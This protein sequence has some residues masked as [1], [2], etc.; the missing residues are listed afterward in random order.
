[1]KI[2]LMIL[3]AVFFLILFKSAGSQNSQNFKQEK[4]SQVRIFSQGENADKRIID[5]GLL[6]DHA[7]RKADYTDA[8]L[9]ESEIKMLDNSGV[10]YN[11]LIPDW[12]NYYE[13]LPKMSRSEIQ[14]SI[15]NSSA[16]FNVSHSIYGTMGGFLKYSEVTAKLDSMRLQYPDLISTKFSIGSTV[17]NRQIWTV[18][19]TKNPDSPTG[20]PEAWYHSLIHA[21]EPESMQHM[22]FYIYWLLENY[23]IDPIAAYILNNRELY[24]TPVLNPDGYVYNETTNPN[25]GGMWRK[26]RKFN[27]SNYGVDL[28]RNYGIYQ[29]WNSSN[30]GSSTSTSSSTYRGTSPFSESETQAAMN[31]INS[32]NINSV[33][34]SHTYGN[35]IIKP[36]AWSDPSPTPD[37]AKFNEY[38]ADMS[39]YNNYI[40]G[41]PL[42]TVGYAVRGCA[43]DW[44]Y[45]DSAH[46]GHNII[47]VT[48]ETGLTGFWPAQS[49]IIP[50]AE[51]MLFTNQYLALISGAYVFPVSSNLN[52]QIYIPGESGTLNLIFKNKG[53][54]S[55]QNVKVEV[56][57]PSFYLNIPITSFN[58]STLSSFQSDSSIFGF[59]VSPA[60]PLNSALPLN[61]KFR[62][63]DS[64]IVYQETKY[65][66]TGNGALTLSDSAE[67]GF[68]K[69][70]TNSGWA[71]T[72]SQSHTPNNSFTD[73][74]SGNYSNNTNNSMTLNIPVDISSVPV[75]FLNFWHRYNTEA[76]YDFCYV[77]VSSNN[78]SSWQTVKSYNGVM[79]TWTEQNIDITSFA[80]S[81][82]QLKIRFRLQSDQGVVADGWY[83]DDIKLKN[84]SPLINSVVTNLQLTLAQEGLYNSAQ[85][86][87]NMNDTV[88][89]YLKSVTSP[90]Q[91]IDSSRGVIDSL[92]FTG[93]FGFRNAPS[94]NY[95]I[96]VKHRNSIET[97]SKAGGEEY[98]FGGTLSYDFTSSVS[99]AFGDNMILTGSKYCI[100]S[101][102]ADQNGFV[103]I[104]DGT[105]ID[106]D[107]AIF[108][109]GY[110]P[111][112]LNGDGITDV[113]DAVFADNNSYN[114]IS[115]IVP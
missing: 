65:V 112:D 106:N 21:R 4:Y 3:A 50:L 73:S 76:G 46:T 70:T 17:E 39:R 44:Y 54:L 96:M 32:R 62:Q 27:G 42:S 69:W 15:S 88:S 25:G 115:K 84:Y 80:N 68:G 101:A 43:D 89:V 8:W 11:I 108:A 61:I 36:W 2:N 55:A 107:A 103:D 5:A 53:Q 92:T 57:S 81:S 87:L 91:N 79:T 7:V 40:T 66:L 72:S 83:I 10:P 60:V 33:M 6:I 16:Q 97:W 98:N 1:M 52:K 74:P 56:T 110:I 82:S 35:Y 12:E 99:Q 75:T 105:L 109:G 26:N 45:N 86:S 67:N 22:I 100:Y 23:N 94:G 41:T 24:F 102:D 90:Y 29:Y 31:F 78:G 38:L 20:R 63:N 71:V 77:E 34:G 85:N 104:G 18:R 49:E 14:K 30:N 19:V 93:N 59:T 9:S 58:Y 48:P 28:N 13:S 114:F 95:F 113:T 37:D 111:T 64:D 47:A 51:S